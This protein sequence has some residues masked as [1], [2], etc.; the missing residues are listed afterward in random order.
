MISLVW[1]PAAGVTAMSQQARRPIEELA[2][3][4]KAIYDERVRPLVDPA[5]RG[6]IV[7]IDVESGDYELADDTLSATDRL[8]AR[9]P[10]AQPWILR[11]G[12]AGVHR[13]AADGV[14]RPSRFLA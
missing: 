7:A 11:V 13:F 1:T 5:E 10:D 3:L 6:R 4:G 12:H 9:R 8:Y 14:C 2:R